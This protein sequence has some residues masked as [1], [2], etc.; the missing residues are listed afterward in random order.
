MVMMMVVIFVI[1]IVASVN[2][3]VCALP[4]FPQ[5]GRRSATVRMLSNCAHQIGACSAR[6]ILECFALVRLVIS[7]LTCILQDHLLIILHS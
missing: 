5:T 2:G 7:T 6:T 1:S 4:M 3:Q